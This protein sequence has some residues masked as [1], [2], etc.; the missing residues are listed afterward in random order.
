MS[1]MENNNKVWLYRGLVVVGAGLMLVTWFMPWWTIDVEGFACDVVQIRPWGLEICDQM[2]DFEVLMKGAEMPAWF[3]TLMWVYLGVCM[4][5]L[6]LS[7][8]VRGKGISLGKFKFSL[9][10][11]LIGG[12]GASYVV[13]GIVA[14]VYA[15][16]RMKQA[17][18]VPLVGRAFIDMGDPIIAYVDTKLL[19]GYFLIYAA[20]LM[21]LG[22]GLFRNKITGESE[23]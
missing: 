3:G 18:D 5:A 1:T 16:Y 10:Q 13:A 7:L 19:P 8:F 9:S 4:V 23:A 6:V 2:G 22:L 12:V 17:F 20:G 21:L 14:A 15:A 11:L